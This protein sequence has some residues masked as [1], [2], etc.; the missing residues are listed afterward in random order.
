MLHCNAQ[1]NKRWRM[2]R[3]L[4]LSASES[5]RNTSNTRRLLVL[6][7]AVSVILPLA[8]VRSMAVVLQ[9]LAAANLSS[10][11]PQLRAIPAA[12]TT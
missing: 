10:S 7:V 12:I 4:R 11:V 2:W 6:K 8:M 1:H 3:I 5:R 9:H